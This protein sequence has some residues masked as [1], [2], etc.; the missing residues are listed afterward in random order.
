MAVRVQSLDPAYFDDRLQ[1][2]YLE[3]PT[4]A[5]GTG[6]DREYKDTGVVR[7]TNDGA[8]A[9]TL[10]AATLD[11]PFALQS[12]SSLDGTTLAP[13]ASID[14]V[15]TFDR[16]KY[17]PPTGSTFDIDAV[18]TV[19]EGKLSVATTDPVSRALE[20]DLAGFWQLKPEAGQEPSLNEMWRVFGFG[21][22]IEGLTT[23]RGGAFSVL[24]TLDVYAAVDET[25]VLSPYWR[26]APGYDEAT[27]TQIAAY[28]G[29]GSAYFGIHAYG[30][31][32]NSIRFWPG[33]VDDN[34]QILPNDRTGSDNFATTT[35]ST[36][37]L[38]SDWFGEI[39]GFR[40]ASQSSDPTLNEPGDILLGVDGT[41]YKKLN[42][43]QALTPS[44]ETVQI[45]SLD[46]VQQGHTIKIFQAVDAA[47][48]AIDHVYLGVMDYPGE[49]HN[50]DYNDNLF[51]L[52]GVAPVNVGGGL[53]VSGLDDAAADDRLVFTKIN[54]PNTFSST[55]A[56]GGQEFRDTAVI[57]LTN[58]GLV[59]VTV[60]D[61]S[62]GGDN[63]LAFKVID[64]PSVIPAGGSVDVTVVMSGGDGVD[65]NKARAYAATLTI[66][67]DSLENPTRTIALGGLAQYESER[68]EE[69]TVAEIVSAFGYTTD[70]AQDALANGG[71]VEAVGDEVLMPYFERLDSS[72]PVE[73]IQIAS[74]LQQND[75]ARL[76][77]HSI[78]DAET[79]P[80]L[81]QD[82]QQGQTVLPD[83]LV[84]G[85][86]NTGSVARAQIDSDG[87]FGLHV[88]VDGKPTYASWS[89]ENANRLDPA[90]SG[91][92]QSNRGHLMR[93]FQAFDEHGDAMVGTYIVIQDYPGGGNYDYNDA[94]YVIT[95]VRSHDLTIAEDADSDGVNDA[96]QSDRDGDGVVDFFDGGYDG[97]GSADQI[98]FNETGTP[99]AVDGDGL[100]LLAN[101]FDV[102]GEGVSY[103]DLSD[104]KRGVKDVRTDAA[105]D[106]SSGELAV[107]YIEAGEWLEY[108]IDVE[109][110]GDYILQLNAATPLGGR[111]VTTTFAVAGS[112][113]ETATSSIVDTDSF[114]VFT[115]SDFET[116]SL[117]SGEQVLRVHFNDS[118]MDLYSISLNLAD[119]LV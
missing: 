17:V 28:H 59:D 58:D 22:E 43:V 41:R 90:L 78:N 86:G 33:G 49:Y 25:E 44:G 94:I 64:A 107:G 89:D 18:S 63:P 96:L 104:D 67:T 39:F 73:I 56:I 40:I 35:L 34:Q 98:A 4:E 21:N 79:L 60:L 112:V 80:L 30:D 72:K 106:I 95:N 66:T 100:T 9:V 38:P 118:G 88:T 71:R 11:G 13:G 14:V 103:H 111:S 10:T 109:K 7:F 114:Y 27:I 23:K 37:D 36:A 52:E 29:P 53:I 87:P 57:T 65:D 5:D 85:P 6:N 110:A 32:S 76:G 74:Y 70:M 48:V 62:V 97:G 24:Q 84:V 61:M 117:R 8:T 113:Y 116:V 16:S 15:V 81:A 91:I 75:I 45:S 3:D 119:S 115:D 54:N 102:G 47:G 55:T 2:S 82:D 50:Y 12:P 92:V 77:Y 20:V 26:V 83:G 69:P 68:G 46:L 108:T 31:D 19:F 42:S 101:L 93:A 99:W 1:F 105:V 51:L